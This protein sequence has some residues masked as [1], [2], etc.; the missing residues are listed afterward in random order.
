MVPVSSRRRKKRPAD[1]VTQL[2]WQ[3]VKNPYKPIKVLSADHIEHIHRASLE[4]IET[5]GVDMW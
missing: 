3:R 2:P 5:L 4:I 1:A